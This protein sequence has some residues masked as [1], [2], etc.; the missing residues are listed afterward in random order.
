MQQRFVVHGAIRRATKEEVGEDGGVGQFG[1]GG[2]FELQAFN[3]AGDGGADFDVFAVNGA[4]GEEVDGGVGD[5]AAGEGDFAAFD[6]QLLAVEFVHTACDFDGAFGGQRTVRALDDGHAAFEAD[7][8]IFVL[9]V[10]FVAQEDFDVSF[11][12][13]GR[14][15][16]RQRL[17]WVFFVEDNDVFGDFDAAAGVGDGD[18]G[19][20]DV[21]FAFDFNAAGRVDGDAEVG[22]DADHHG[23]GVGNEHVFADEREVKAGRRKVQHAFGV[24]VAV[25]GADVAV[26]VDLSA[27]VRR[28]AEADIFQFGRVL[29][30]F[31]EAV[32]ELQLAADYRRFGATA[33]LEDAADVAA[34]FA[35]FRHEV[36]VLAD[37]RDVHFDFA[38]KRLFVQ[39]AD[40]GAAVDAAAVA[41]VDGEGVFCLAVGEAGAQLRGFDGE[42]ERRLAFDLDVDVA[43]GEV[44]VGVAAQLAAV[45]DGDFAFALQRGVQAD[46]FRDE[47]AE[48]FGIQ[49]ADAV[50]EFGLFVAFE[51]EAEAAVGVG[52]AEVAQGDLFGGDLQGAALF[53]APLHVVAAGFQAVDV[54]F[55]GIRRAEAAAGGELQVGVAAAAAQGEAVAVVV[56]VAC[57]LDVFPVLSGCLYAL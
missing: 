9:E 48:A 45:G 31:D 17:F 19:F 36:A 26:D 43:G 44:Q 24:E 35:R 33:E 20:G 40:E 22:R 8:Y 21:D 7:V 6:V 38:G 12:R 25:R 23:F 56:A 16:R 11:E 37:V 41:K 52:E 15:D 49:G 30:D 51:V 28:E 46:V 32:F 5:V 13:Y 18:V 42:V 3:A 34:H 57:E 54:A 2:E 29:R 47:F 10:N 53:Q 55:P 1:R 14:L 4:Q 50:G 39:V 27:A